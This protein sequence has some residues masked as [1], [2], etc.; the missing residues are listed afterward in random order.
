MD[1]LE[2]VLKKY[3]IENWEDLPVVISHRGTFASLFRELAF[4]KGAE[5]GV[6]DGENAKFL[7]DNIPNLKLFCIDPWLSYHGLD[8]SL[9]QSR[10]DGSYEATKKT[11]SGYNCEIIRE[12][13]LEAAKV[14]ADNSLDFVFIDGNHTFQ[15]V[16]NDI[17]EWSRKV[18]KGGIVSGHD[19]HADPGGRHPCHVQNVVRAWTEVYHIRPWFHIK[20]MEKCNMWF[21]V[22]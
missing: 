8:R 5:I 19:F 17:A 10:Q 16:T 4:A 22:K 7:L 21:W 1:T 12:F 14:I 20:K 11:L 3:G 13:S 15:Y 18:R 2:F 9:S 6:G